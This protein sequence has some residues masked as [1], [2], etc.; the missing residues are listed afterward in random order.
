MAEEAQSITTTLPLRKPIPPVT[1]LKLGSTN[2]HSALPRLSDNLCILLLSWRVPTRAPPHPTTA[3]S[4]CSQFYSTVYSERPRV[5]IT[6]STSMVNHESFL[7]G[8]FVAS[9]TQ[10]SYHLG[11]WMVH[12]RA[13]RC[14]MPHDGLA[15]EYP[16]RTIPAFLRN[17]AKAE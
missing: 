2:N 17:I 6:L 15:A 16:W 9:Y 1:N 10:V 12:L 11:A 5:H 7:F 4:L 8:F 3:Q 14:K 13:L